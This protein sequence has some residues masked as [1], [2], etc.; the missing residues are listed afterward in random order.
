MKHPRL[1]FVIGPTNAGKGH[2]LDHLGR[3]PNIGLVEVG[4][5]FRAKYLDPKS[6]H[7]DPDYFKGQAAPTHTAIEAWQMMLDGIRSCLD[8][9]NHTI[10]VDGQPRDVPQ[11]IQIINQFE[12]SGDFDVEYIHVYAPEEIRR[13]RAALRDA[14]DEA[15]LKLSEARMLGDLVKLYEV[16]TRLINHGSIINTIYNGV[17]ADMAAIVHQILYHEPGMDPR[18]RSSRLW[19]T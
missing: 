13:E 8:N 4:K 19:N 14:G 5:M 16:L 9:G 3:Q 17:D 6:P 15:K 12:R 10:F 1:F 7:Y 2:L 11:C 18:I